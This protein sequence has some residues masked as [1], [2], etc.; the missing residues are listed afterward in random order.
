MNLANLIFEGEAIA[1]EQTNETRA[2]ETQREHHGGPGD[3]HLDSIYGLAGFAALIGACYAFAYFCEGAKRL[4][5]AIR[6]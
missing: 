2:I 5:N 6:N 1:L 4:Y 3:V